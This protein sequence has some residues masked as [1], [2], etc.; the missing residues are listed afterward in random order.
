[1]LCGAAGAVAADEGHRRG[2]GF[3]EMEG[4]E[5]AARAMP[6]LRERLRRKQ[7]DAEL[8]SRELDGGGTFGGG[9]RYGEMGDKRRMIVLMSVQGNGKGV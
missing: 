1:M 3:V 5:G 8:L 6:L 2:T 7:V 9:V 4:R